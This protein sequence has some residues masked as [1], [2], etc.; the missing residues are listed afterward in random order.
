V[1][2]LLVDGVE[3]EDTWRLATFRY[4][5]LVRTLHF[6]PR[7]QQFLRRARHLVESGGELVIINFPLFTL[8]YI[9]QL[10]WAKSSEPTGKGAYKC[11]V[12]LELVNGWI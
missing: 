8:D 12:L 10:H 2:F 7:A 5:F 1:D 11:L 4:I 6:I 9:N 3:L